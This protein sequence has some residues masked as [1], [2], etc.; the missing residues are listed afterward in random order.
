MSA[1][2]KDSVIS[3]L[4]GLIGRNFVAGEVSVDRT[5]DPDESDPG[6]SA[7]L[8]GP[9]DGLDALESFTKMG[10]VAFG[11]LT[12]GISPEALQAIHRRDKEVVSH[13]LENERRII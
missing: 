9:T 12:R 10:P 11:I 7:F 5:S 2:E 1:P 8:T 6:V 4:E 13:E 3:R